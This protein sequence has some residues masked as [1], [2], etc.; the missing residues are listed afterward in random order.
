MAIRDVQ[1]STTNRQLKKNPALF[2]QARTHAQGLGRGQLLKRSANL[3]TQLQSQQGNRA[4]TRAKLQG[5]RRTLRQDV[6][7]DRYDDLKGN[8]GAMRKALK[9]KLGY[10]AFSSTFYTKPKGPTSH[11]TMRI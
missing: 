11:P 2:R 9:R 1:R 10:K 3:Q 8:R 4:D 7:G 6:L 5:Y